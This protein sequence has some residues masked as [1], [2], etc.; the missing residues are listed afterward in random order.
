[1]T[2]LDDRI[3]MAEESGELTLDV[4]FEWLEKMPIPEGTKVEVVGGNIFMSPQRQTHFEIIFGILEQM[5]A[6]YPLQRLASDVRVDFPGRL[7]GFACDVAAFRDRSVKD[8]NGRWR[9]Q[10]VEFVAEVIS[11]DT[12]GNDYGPKKAAYAQ[13]GVPVY[14]VA[15]PYTGICHVYTRPHKG[16]YAT[17]TKVPFGDEVDLTG[18]VVGLVLS[19]DEFPRD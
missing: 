19:T 13:A 5:R 8:R 7:N 10:D 12:A 16:D 4:M 2:V 18:T 6:T 9:Y 15:D 1:M 3:E 11:K 17:E 14:L